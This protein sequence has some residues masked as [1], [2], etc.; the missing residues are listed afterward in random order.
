MVDIEKLTKALDDESNESL[1]NFTTKKIRELNVNVLNELDLDVKDKRNILEKLKGYRYVDEMNELK[2]GTYLR[3]IPLQDPTNLELSK[4]A[5]LCEVNIT[6]EGIYLVCRNFGYSGKRFQLNMGECLIFRKLT[7]QE[8][9]LLSALDH[10][11][12]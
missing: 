9:V 8:L 10:L 7:D 3:W 12:K 2:N 5:L 6:N 4:G 1:L 11:S